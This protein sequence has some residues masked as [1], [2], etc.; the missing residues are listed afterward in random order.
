VTT[1]PV[2]TAQRGAAIGGDR[3]TRLSAWCRTLYPGS[4]ALTMASG[5]VSTGLLRE[6]AALSWALF[7]VGLAGF[8]VLSVALVARAIVYRDALAGDVLSPARTFGFFTFSAGANV[9]AARCLQAHW[10]G[11]GWAFLVVGSL[12][13]LVLTYGI[14]AVL[15]LE[16]QGEP[17]LPQVNGGWLIWVVS[18]QSV[19]AVSALAA[20]MG[21][22]STA[23]AVA[24][25]V[26]VVTWG[27]GVAL[28][29][30][31]ITLILG[32]LLL[33]GATRPT[34]TPP[35]WIAM[36][37]TAISVLAGARILA[38]PTH[39]ALLVSAAPALRGISF[40][41]WSFGTWWIP[42]L[43][44][45]GVWRYGRGRLRLAYEPA[46]WSIVF[47]LGMYAEASREFGAVNGIDFLG[48]LAHVAV[49]VAFSAWCVVFAG[50]ALSVLRR[51]RK[52]QRPMAGRRR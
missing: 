21:G 6:S 32:R 18:T 3:A 41:L 43:V 19:A 1:E 34:L 24:L 51:W 8:G 38:V 16:H 26:A 28:Y 22:G 47:P 25:R 35:Y 5:I 39:D 13:W 11:A 48:P 31:L 45:M 42:M 23:G 7:V 17:V 40:I 37:A 36:G 20:T 29:L 27:V 4:F 49:W 30:V 10:D 9:L 33:L 46:L 14:P 2:G 52:R 12:A 50:M 15:M 44:L